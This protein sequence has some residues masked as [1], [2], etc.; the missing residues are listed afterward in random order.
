MFWQQK[1]SIKVKGEEPLKFTE[2]TQNQAIIFFN[3][4]I[5]SLLPQLE[6]SLLCSSNIDNHHHHNV[7][8]SFED[9]SGCTCSP[10]QLLVGMRGCGKASRSISILSPAT[11]SHLSASSTDVNHP[12]EPMSQNRSNTL[13]LS[14]SLHLQFFPRNA[15]T[16]P[17]G[18][19]QS[20]SS[21]RR[22][23]TGR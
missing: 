23:G 21:H 8:L 6:R 2:Q 10:P 7:D 3:S 13:F 15:S 5:T 11:V 9:I 20:F 18:N 14:I 17:Q 22:Q 4:H 12:L 16:I 1:S 19:C